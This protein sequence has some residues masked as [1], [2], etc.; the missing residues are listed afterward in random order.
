MKLSVSKFVGCVFGAGMALM[1]ACGGSNTDA[2]DNTDLEPTRDTRI[3]DLADAACDRYESCNG[4]GT[5]SGQTYESESE[6]QA[7]FTSK[8][9]TLWP[10]DK[11]DRGQIN[12]GAYENCT[13]AVKG[14]ACSGNILDAIS[15]LEDCRS[16]K[17]CTDSPM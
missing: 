5:G 2:A 6:C 15:A 17:V 7:D 12:N 14:V 4:Y 10:T 13:N 16:G 9:D 11:C 1:T 8:A 3:K